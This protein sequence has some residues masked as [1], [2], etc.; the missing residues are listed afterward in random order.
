MGKI[1]LVL[2]GG[3]AKGAYQIGA[4]Q[5]LAEHLVYTDIAYISAASVGAING[6]AFS[7]GKL[8]QAADFWRSIND[9]KEKLFLTS[10][11]KSDF[12]QC[13]LALL[14]KQQPACERLYVPLLHLLKRDLL[15]WEIKSEDTEMRR[16]LLSAAIAFPPF[17]KPVRVG[18]RN[19]YDGALVDNIPVSPLMGLDV[20]YIVCMYFDK[21][22][23]TF[24]SDFYDKK[25]IKISFDDD[26]TFLS[27]SF[28]FTRERI[29]GM[30][31]SGYEKAR[32]ILEFVF[33]DGKNGEA[34]RSR[35]KAL[36]AL[37]PNRDF[38]ITGDVIINNFNKL[39]KCMAKRTIEK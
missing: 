26:K 5:A 8:E 31:K 29:D 24:E 17:T 32:R 39:T 2:S 18:E 30:I 12:L 9:K 23:Y 34:V 35:I 19:F 38:R 4:L 36:N 10:A 37:Y 15:Y 27:E 28:W 22:H 1:G 13:A 7:A 3:M 14:S 33:C 20:D 16:L 11:Y 6:L 25:I 21:Y